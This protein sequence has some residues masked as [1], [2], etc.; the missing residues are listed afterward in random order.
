V[1]PNDPEALAAAQ[2]AAAAAREEGLR[3]SV[4]PTRAQVQGIAAAAVHDPGRLFDDDV[5]LM[6]AAAGATRDGAL[7]LVPRPLTGR[8]SGESSDRTWVG[9]VAGEALF[10][11]S[12]DAGTD[13]AIGV[14]IRV[15]DRL[16]AGGGELVTLVAGTGAEP[17]L[18]QGVQTHLARAHAGVEVSVHDGG[19]EGYPL[20]IG[21][22]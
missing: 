16:L 3:I 22:E 8:T 21:V 20:L 13:A 11:A 9:T 19:Q 6:S 4:V 15:V 18:L 7:T 17:A 2:A 5:V 12:A 10:T 1:L 14:A